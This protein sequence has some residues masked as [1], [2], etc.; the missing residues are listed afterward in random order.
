LEHVAAEVTS[1]RVLLA[2]LR[3][4]GGTHLAEPAAKQILR[5]YG[6]ATPA[7]FVAR[8]RAEAANAFS[9]LT[10]PVA[11][12]LVSSAILHKS[13]VGGVILALTTQKETLAAV[14]RLA[15]LASRHGWPLDGFLIEEMVVPGHEIVIGGVI[16]QRFGPV[17][18]LGL[19]GVF[20]EIFNDVAFGI[21][22]INERDA[23]RMI[24]ELK[25]APLLLQGARGRPL[26]DQQALCDCLL[27]IG[28][29]SGL[30]L[31]LADVVTELDINP[32][33]AS[34][35]D[36]IAVDARIII[37]KD[38]RSVSTF[39][40]SRTLANFAPLFN[41]SSIAV[42]GA[43]AT[44][45]SLGNQFLSRL[46]AYGYAGKIFAVHPTADTVDGVP[47]IRSLGAAG[48]VIDYAYVAVPPDEV[49]PT[50]RGGSGRVRFAQIITSGFGESGDGEHREQDLVAAIEES[51]IR[52]LGPNC[53]GTH[54]P[55]G[56]LTY[57]A[58]AS[59]T[60]GSCGI[61]CQSGGLSID[62]VQ[63]G[64]LIGL[65]FSGVVT[66]G[67]SIDLS[68][69]DML[70]FF[71][72]DAQTKVVGVYVEGMREGRRFFELLRSAGSAKP[73][74]ILVGG[75]TQQG[76]RA[77]RSHTGALATDLKMWQA[78]AAS[79]GSVLSP[80]LDAFL[81]ALVAFS[82]LQPHA[83]ASRSNIV[84][85]GNGG[86]ASVLAAD[87]FA[88]C[89]LRIDALP[90]SAGQSLLDM[91]LPPGS[92]V[93]NPIDI[94]AGNL[95]AGNGRVM[96]Q[97]IDTVLSES[98]ASALVVHLNLEPIL[99]LASAEGDPLGDLTQTML[100]VLDG[101]QSQLHCLLVLRTTGEPEME[102]RRRTEA[103]RANL[104]GVPVFDSLEG[105]AIGLA[106]IH[107]LE[108]FRAGDSTIPAKSDGDP[109]Q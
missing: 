61:V 70:E 92:S 5:S 40:S 50:L 7:G 91:K 90:V 4:A 109:Q 41:P 32:L 96:A 84:L 44:R 29:D 88:E 53:L 59:P 73:V 10:P 97:V 80:T 94:P 106:A 82:Y 35:S 6:V 34:G 8:D 98:E 47:A 15:N 103:Q 17:L 23:R 30:L 54:S 104:G 108:R 2:D 75:R 76:Q 20:V 39:D 95:I 14:D 37:G 77:A 9:R 21:C 85:L 18:M 93:S 107:G 36:I 13:D 100:E 24:N 83:D 42:V 46:R 48:E 69:P 26:V 86:G 62:I 56:H 11:V 45:K 3:R 57:L 72:H 65:N 87:Y 105:A 81:A 78:L 52:V 55:R 43:S 68:P 51:G 31:D 79:T 27:K 38:A 49:A 22:P 58:G 33:M 60:Q 74:V 101:H 12:K 64:Q 1:S 89:G 19:G 28:G 102:A 63:R 25:A 71:L 16:D 66:L 67:N 99:S